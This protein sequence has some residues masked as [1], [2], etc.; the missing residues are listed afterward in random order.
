VRAGGMGAGGMGTMASARLF[1]TSRGGARGYLSWGC[2]GGL[3]CP[4]DAGHCEPQLGQGLLGCHGAGTGW[5]L[6]DPRRLGLHLP[7]SE[8]RGG[9]WA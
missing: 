6:R 1:T 7:S 4:N 5:K 3:L 9:G 2:S 8:G